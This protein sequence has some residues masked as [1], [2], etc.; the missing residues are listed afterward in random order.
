MANYHLSVKTG[1]NVGSSGSRGASHY[2]YINREGKYKRDDIEQIESGNLPSW[3]VDAQHFWKAADKYE[4]AN[5]RVYTELEISLPR[6]LN[7]EQRQE[8]VQQF[9]EKTLGKNFTYSY[10][11][12][13]PLASD[14]EQNPHVHLMFCERKLDGIDRTEQQFFRRYNPKNP[15]LGGAGKDRYFSARIFVSDV[16]MEWANHANDYMEKLGLDARIDHRSYQAIGTEIQSQNF[17]ADYVSHDQYSINENIK[18]IKH[19][20]GETIIEKPSEVLKVLTANQSVFT[21]REL[22]RFLVNHTD[23]EEQYLKAREAV[24]TCP[25]MA[26]LYGKDS[27]VLSSNE[28]VGI[29]ESISTLIYNA[30]QDSRIQKPRTLID[31]LP[32]NAVRVAETRT[33]NPEQEKAFYT[34][35]STDRISL[36][37][38]S[39]GTGKSYVLSAVSEAYKDSDYQVYGIALQ[40][41]TAKAIASDCDIPSSTIAS[42]LARYE[43]GN[44]AINDKTVLILD[45]AG[46]VGSR[47][48]Q[49][50]LMITEQHNAQLKLVGDS[51][52]LNAVM[53]GSA[54]NHIQ[55]NL[56]HKNIATLEN[57][58]RQ[59]TTEMRKASEYLS[60]HEVDKALDIYQAL[61]KVKACESH[62][63][64]LARTIHS[65]SLDH[66][67]SKLILAHSNRDVDELNRMARSVLIKQGKLPAESQ[68][69]NTYKG[70]IDLATGDKI[71]FKQNN[72]ALNISNGETAR[73]IGFERNAQQQIKGLMVESDRGGQIKK[74]DLDSYQHFKHGYANT[75]HSS[76]GMT[77][78]NAYILASEN[79]NANLTYVAL[80]RHKGN[81]ELNYSATKFNQE[82]KIWVRKPDG[83]YQEKELSAFDN[84]KRTLGRTEVK[85]FSTDYSVVQAKD[86]LI[87][88]YLQEHRHSISEKREIYNLNS[89]FKAMTMPDQH[90]S[91]QEI[92]EEV[93]NS[94]RSK[95]ILG[96]EIVKFNG[97]MNIAKGEQLQLDQELILKTGLFKKEHFEKDTSL[98]VVDAYRV[99]DEPIMKARIKGEIY[100]IPFDKLHIRYSDKYLTEFRQDTSARF[101]KRFKSE[102]HSK[103]NQELQQQRQNQPTQ[104]LNAPNSELKNAPRMKNGPR[105]S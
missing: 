32:L 66:S 46:M 88:N 5:G 67:E 91:K 52:Q 74:I 11:I 61:G 26:V 45:E 105:M 7:Q 63:V 49:K 58:Q 57:I 13:T 39:A 81:V 60:K 9:V 79:M 16:R 59:K 104:N 98:Q 82:E 47:D 6:E 83:Q 92:I 62:E 44:I 75:I 84:L 50:L 30:N 80:T 93:R 87:K 71:V 65:W 29:E 37:N 23:G 12:H 48:M 94:L 72:H 35:T 51:Y 33:F 21:M 78:E 15:E 27:V 42:F 24:L 31:K 73:I 101:D 77:V 10:A 22:D 19:Q 95:A 96:D 4:R 55:K 64:A 2:A 1:K 43:S 56:D 103:F 25:E 102:L 85:N 28:L 54:F 17:R 90:F 100:E 53:A 70:E 34:L 38:G 18:N 76:Q 14:G 40:A 41:I 3:A 89:T 99:K 86:E 36:L 68:K 8:L 97:Q 20:N 69:V